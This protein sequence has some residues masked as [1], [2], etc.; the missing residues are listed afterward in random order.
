MKFKVGIIGCGKIGLLNDYDKPKKKITYFSNLLKNRYFNLIAVTD[1]NLKKLALVRAKSSKIKLYKNYKDMLLENTFDL[2]IV[3]TPTKSYYSIYKN[4]SNYNNIKIVIAEKPFL[5]DTKTYK[6][7]NK[8]FDKKN[9]ITSVNYSR[10]FNSSYLIIKKHLKKINLQIGEVIINRGLYNNSSHY[11]DLL[12]EL[13]GKIKSIKNVNLKKS[14]IINED[15]YGTFDLEFK[16]RIKIHFNILEI[17]NL[18]YERLTFFGKNDLL[19][20]FNDNFYLYKIY[21]QKNSLSKLKK[22]FTQ[23][24]NY[25]D[26]IE[27]HLMNIKN[28]LVKKTKLKSTG[29]NAFLT[30]KALKMIVKKNEIR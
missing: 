12:I 15:F 6:K 7:I 11:I 18:S 1:I 27:N 8:I 17:E 30:S 14:K 4:L 20:I 22:K 5:L 24:I 3:S 19:E 28:F 29:K 13:F 2:I 9:I 21:M 10:K 26:S 16:N 23:K 25:S